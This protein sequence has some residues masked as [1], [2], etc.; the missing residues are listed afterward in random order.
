MAVTSPKEHRRVVIDGEITR[1][2]FETIEREVK[3]SDLITEI[4][5]FSTVSSGILPAGC[6]FYARRTD[7]KN[8]VNQVFLLELMAHMQKIVWRRKPETDDE[9]RHPEKCFVD[10]TLS[11]PNTLWFFL[12][13]GKNF[14]S[15][16]LTASSARFIEKGLETELFRLP[17]PNQYNN[18]DGPFCTGNIVADIALSIEARVEKIMTDLLSS[19][20]NVDLPPD[21]SGVGIENM[22]DWSKKS[23]DPEFY[24]K[25]KMRVNSARTANDL[26]RSFG[27]GD[28]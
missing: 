21:Y 6:V 23:E 9:H 14:Q 16:Y 28:L 24:K 5:R 13:Q 8:S 7:N 22:E 19:A 20:W 15:V 26:L 10:L 3:T 27:F 12:F 18:G 1:I 25:L 2:I 17:M 11:W 4:T